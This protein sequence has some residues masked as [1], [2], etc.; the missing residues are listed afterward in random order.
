MWSSPLHAHLLQPATQFTALPTKMQPRLEKQLTSVAGVTQRHASGPTGATT[1]RPP[2]RGTKR[3]DLRAGLR[4]KPRA[5][6]PPGAAGRSPPAAAGRARLAPASRQIDVPG[7]IFPL[8]LPAAAAVRT[9]GAVPSH[10][11]HP[12]PVPVPGTVL[13]PPRGLR[14]RG[15]QVPA[16]A[17]AHAARAPP[18]P[19]V[20]CP[21]PAPSAPPGR[22]C[23][24]SLPQRARARRLQL[25]RPGLSVS[26][27]EL[28]AFPQPGLSVTPPRS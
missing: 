20:P 21:P 1:A 13:F 28:A 4:P 23:G 2:R 8:L 16:P 7:T 24:L 19:A 14:G 12:T 15:S 18:A 5:A 11:Q 6:V 26:G 17:A 27:S 22:G 9:E 25:T 10:S 3:A